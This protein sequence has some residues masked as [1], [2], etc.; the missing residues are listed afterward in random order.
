M[1][2]NH[3]IIIQMVQITSKTNPGLRE[4]AAWIRPRISLLT[5]RS[6]YVPPWMI[7]TDGTPCATKTMTRMIVIAMIVGKGR[8]NHHRHLRHSL[9]KAPGHQGLHHP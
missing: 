5:S 8:E 1:S 2:S 9:P 7:W 4:R 3:S 6:S